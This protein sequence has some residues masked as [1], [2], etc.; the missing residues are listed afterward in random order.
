MKTREEK[1]ED[2]VNKFDFDKLHKF[3]N[4]D[5]NYD[6]LWLKGK[7]ADQLKECARKAIRFSFD[8]DCPNCVYDG[9]WIGR[10]Y[11][12]EAETIC[13]C[14]IFGEVSSMFDIEREVINDNR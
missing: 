6:K 1:I 11:R 7:S 8:E 14:F 12:H 4:S 5:A 10:D 13:L 9:F 3:I 2:V